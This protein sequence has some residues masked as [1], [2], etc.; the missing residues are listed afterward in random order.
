M[1]EA[2]GKSKEPPIK[3]KKLSVKREA[4]KD[5]EPRRGVKAGAGAAAWREP[6][7]KIAVNHN[8]TLVVD[9]MP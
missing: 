3:G 1:S 9:T 8:E 4:V 2:K 5:L 7:G 6:T